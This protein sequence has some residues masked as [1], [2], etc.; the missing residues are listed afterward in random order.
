[1]DH[2]KN[3]NLVNLNHNIIHNDKYFMADSGY[4]SKV[5]KDTIKKMN[6]IPLIPQNKRNIKN[7]DLIIKFNEKENKIYTKRLTIER[8]I[9]R[10]KDNRKICL[11]YES[12]ISNFEG[13][14]YL[15]LIKFMN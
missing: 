5:I 1:M 8:M 6:Y 10:L 9:K 7:P 11:R 14:V 4:D 13:F 2:L 12:K 15:A 3:D